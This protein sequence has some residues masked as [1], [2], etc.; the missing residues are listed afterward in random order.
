MRASRR[1]ER[2][3]VIDYAGSES[4]ATYPNFDSR[5]QPAT[6]FNIL[7]RVA[8]EISYKETGVKVIANSANLEARY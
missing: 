4:D 5:S 3:P 2:H 1:A 7:S 8:D 6:Q